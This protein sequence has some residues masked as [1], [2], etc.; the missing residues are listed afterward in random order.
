MSNQTALTQLADHY[1]HYVRTIKKQ[2]KKPDPD[3]V[4]RCL[5][6]RDRIASL[7]KDADALDSQSAICIAEADEA[8]RECADAIAQVD[9]YVSWRES[10][11]P[12]STAWWWHFAPP[13]QTALLK[14]GVTIWV[15]INIT[16]ALAILSDVAPRFLTGGPD[17]WGGVAVIGQGLLV[18]ITSGSLLVPAV[19]ESFEQI[20][21]TL[22]LSGYFQHILQALFATLVVFVLLTI[23]FVFLETFALHYYRS[24]IAHYQANRLALAQYDFERSLL[25]N[26]DSRLTR[27]QL[28]VLYEDLGDLDRARTEYWLAAK[29]GLDVAYNNLAR[30]YILDGESVQAVPL[31]IESINVSQDE[32]DLPT[33]S[34]TVFKNLAWAR[35]EQGPARYDEAL[36]D[37]DVALE[38][39][40]IIKA[41][42]PDVYNTLS[43][44]AP[45]CIRAK[46]L[47]SRGINPRSDWEQCRDLAH[48]IKPDDEMWLGMAQEYFSRQ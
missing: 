45:Y 25:L 13:D 28:G 33:L 43:I 6:L 11:S 12:P 37:A 16:I 29:A 17:I 46:V 7:V 21:R 26:P 14:G 10:F 44:A 40:S 1:D 15:L 47:E 22:N 30:L 48:P 38:L 3:E 39:A 8:L 42:D 27:Y 34:Y 31:L 20:Q 4:I 18:L 36:G 9:K 41:S 24:G 19:R 23:R 5:L 2:I 32:S 35:L